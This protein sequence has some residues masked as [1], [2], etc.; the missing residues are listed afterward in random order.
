[1]RRIL[2]ISL[3]VLALVAG[4]LPVTQTLAKWSR[5]AE[6]GHHRRHRRHSRAWWRRH[7]ALLRA[8]RERAE[9]RRQ[10]Q[11]L[12]A[13]RAAAAN[14]S[15][16][17]GVAPARLSGANAGAGGARASQMP[18]D[19]QVPRTWTP[20]AKAPAGVAAYGVRTPDG[21][22]AGVAVVSPVTLSASDLAAA[23]A[24]PRAKTIGGLPVAALRRTVINRMVAEG[25]WVTNDMIREM[26]GRRV[27]VVVAETGAPGSPAKSWTFYF[28]EVDGRV[29]SLATTTPVEF[30]EP[31]AAASEQLMATL[32]PAGS[33]N[34][35]L[36]K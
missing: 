24:S 6:V 23:P 25:G 28:T 12:A 7:R 11:Q 32:R 14:P 34:M 13:G 33:S 4:G 18:F 10:Q 1:M 19:F 15:L 26:H 3:L 20:L 31:V 5:R 29:Y 22:Q 8:R 30:A 36:Q 2:Y 17:A 9:R 21:R 35:A 27:F 16:P